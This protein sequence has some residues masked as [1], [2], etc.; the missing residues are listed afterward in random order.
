M[1]KARLWSIIKS[2]SFTVFYFILTSHLQIIAQKKLRAL[3][4]M[5]FACQ[6]TDQNH[7]NLCEKSEFD[8]KSSTVK[9]MYGPPA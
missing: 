2:H 8:W 7:V 9:W 6:F 4:F 5:D 1:I 3:T